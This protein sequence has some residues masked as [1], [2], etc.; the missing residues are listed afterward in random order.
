MSY[1]LKRAIFTLSYLSTHPWRSEA[2]WH[3]RLAGRGRRIYLTVSACGKKGKEVEKRKR[4]G[5]GVLMVTLVKNV[6][7]V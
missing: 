2:G 4:G 1:I 5:A 7:L 6:D 3:Q